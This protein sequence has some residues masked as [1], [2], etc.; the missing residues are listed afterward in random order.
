MDTFDYQRS[1]VPAKMPS[2]RSGSLSQ[3]RFDPHASEST[4]SSLSVKAVLRA[5]RRYWWLILALWIVGSA[6]IGAAVYV[7]VK[8][9]YR[10]SSW[11]RVDPTELDLYGVRSAGSEPYMQ[12]HVTLVT[13]QNV[14]SAAAILPEVASWPR[15]RDS[16]NPVQ[17]LR[18]IIQVSI[19]PGTHII[20]VAAVSPVAAEAAAMV[21][22]VVQEFLDL[23]RSWSS[24][25]TTK[26]IGKLKSYQKSLETN[27]KVAETDLRSRVKKLGE[28]GQVIPLIA[29]NQ[30]N[31]E[32]DNANDADGEKK[33]KQAGNDRFSLTVE[34]YKTMLTRLSGIKMELVTAEFNLD[35]T[36]Q[37]VQEAMR[38]KSLDGKKS[39]SMALIDQ[40]ISS[41]PEMMQIRNKMQAARSH[42]EKVG[43]NTGH[44]GDPSEL[45]A[46]QAA[47]RAEQEYQV[48][49]QRKRVLFQSDPNLGLGDPQM[50]L[51]RAEK[52]VQEL[53]RGK[54]SLEQE[55]SK[56]KLET[57]D[58]QSEEFE[59]Q[60]LARDHLHL[61]DMQQKIFEK[62]EQ[63]TFES[64][65]AE[66]RIRLINE[67][68][69]EGIPISD[70]R[71][72]YMAM[73]PVGIL[74]AVLGL[75]VLL[76]LRSGRVAD[77]E[78]LSSRMKHEVFAIAPLP[79][80]RPG[81][82]RDNDKADQRLARFVQSLDHLRV[83]LCEGGLNGEGRCVMITSATGGEGKTTLSAHLAARCANAGTSILLIDADLRRASL[84]RLLDVPQGRGLGDLLS[85]EADLDENLISVQAGGFHFL[86]A[87]TP[88]IDPSR[89]LKST[90]LAE[91]IGQF[92]QMYDLIIIDTPP[93][94][95]V[96]DALIMGRWA[97]GA[98]MAAR[99]DASR[100]P[101]VERANRQI[102]AAGI[103]VLG[104]VVNGVK[105]H[106]QAYGSYAYNYS[107][108]GRQDPL[109]DA[110]IAS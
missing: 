45:A 83:A 16:L 105:G 79:N 85:G 4:P 12:T 76:E 57:A 27:I 100:L 82:G 106:D 31:N 78:I 26:Q 11:L 91:L 14:L 22:A 2:A 47:R 17:E 56:V 1:S 19:Q 58:Q 41:D 75:V 46:R 40:K 59:Y 99:Y 29:N 86:S 93:V 63:L 20:E 92:R 96:A 74:G 81:L 108:P 102:I 39:G 95:P 5:S 87:G 104:V 65:S 53:M 101:L 62:L 94:L 107:Y 97:D 42:A 10:A 89:V 44:H 32:T 48:A 21:N 43:I 71:F 15:M 77:T 18:K 36:R 6:G 67:A 103:P 68:E 28:S 98:V 90:R 69:P 72:Q 9:Q 66:E 49:W 52:T 8:P 64:S 24:G 84:G 7:R 25:M 50:E 34:N 3:Q 35:A 110:D 109:N 61:K 37:A 23:N 30:R 54:T 55:L 60:L 33:S 88:G 13:S 70:K 80:H 51:A 38:E 73:A